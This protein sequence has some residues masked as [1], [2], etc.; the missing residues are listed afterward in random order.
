MKKLIPA[1]AIFGALIQP[2]LSAPPSTGTIMP[3][4]WV[5]GARY[6]KCNGVTDDTTGL[7]NAINDTQGTDGTLLLP[8]GICNI[9]ATVFI[10]GTLKVTGA[11]AGANSGFAATTLEWIGASSTTPMINLQGVQDAFFSDFLIE[12]SVAHPLGIGIQSTTTSPRLSS[13]NVFSRIFMNGTASAGLGKGF[14][15][16][17]GSGG[18]NN[19]DVNSFY[20]VTIANYTK[21]AWSFEHTQ[22]K[23]HRFINCAFNAGSTLANQYGVTTALGTGSTGGS[24]L[25]YGGYGCCNGEA[26]FYLGSP[27]DAIMVSGGN[28]ESSSRFLETSGNSSGSWAVSLIG[29]RWAGDLLNA[30]GKAIIFGQSGPLTI[31]GSTFGIDSTKP[32]QFSMGSSAPIVAA[33][34]G[35]HIYTS[36][37]TPFSGGTWSL[38]GNNINDAPAPRI[39]STL[40]SGQTAVTIANLPTC[41]AAIAGY[42]QVVSNGQTSPAW[43]GA[44]S[45]TGAVYASVGCVQT[46]ASTYG[47]VYQ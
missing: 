17:A 8:S 14:A 10:T 25:W 40:I 43:N 39:P 28:F 20:N 29:V 18:D 44:V 32:L 22:S 37:A 6:M 16:I 15:Y 34:I 5:N 2:A 3:I 23:N 26:D 27:N 4:G 13:A 1:F 19:N 45:T 9:S 38:I 7:Q 11:G 24:F 35:S 12:S 31:M 46:G 41:T 36:L 33:A 21:A 42:K 30:D 47:W